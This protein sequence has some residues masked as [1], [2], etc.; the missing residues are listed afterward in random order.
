MT[1][2]DFKDAE[3]GD[4]LLYRPVAFSV[5]KPFG[6]LFGALIALKTWHHISHVEVYAGNGVWRRHDGTTFT[7]RASF[8]SRDGLGVGVYPVRDTELAYV[9]RPTRFNAVNMS[10][11]L[12]WFVTV[13]G[14][15]YDWLGLT[16][17]VRT[18][19]VPSTTKMFCSAFWLRFYR[20][21]GFNPFSA[22]V[23]ADSIA[24]GEILNC[25]NLDLVWTDGKDAVSGAV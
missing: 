7:G 16:R 19:I 13:E 21:A 1:M 9:L 4:T 5:R 23:D 18:S 12:R 22:R 15:G 2:F 10:A 8:A 3:P 17:F 11:A 14:Q 25:A 20:A 24:P 6:W